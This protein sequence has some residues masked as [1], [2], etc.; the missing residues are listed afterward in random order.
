MTPT[1]LSTLG[2]VALGIAAITWLILREAYASLPPLPWTGIPALLLVAGAEAVIG[3]DV[4]RRI[5][6][7]P[8][9]KP[10]DP[11]AVSR[12]LVLAKASS[13]TGAVVT[14]I[15][16]GFIGYLSGQLA[17]TMPRRDFIYAAITCAATLVLVAA[18]LYL[19]YCCRVPTG[20]KPSEDITQSADR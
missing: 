10:V 16:L 19:E 14:G 20:T 3:R 5:S 6:R 2:I 9:A 15:T 4:R 12:M 11:L 13:L 8:G 1:R 18:A 7:R 17:A